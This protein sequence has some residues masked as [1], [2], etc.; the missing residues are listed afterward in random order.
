[1]ASAYMGP[2]GGSSRVSAPDA[3]RFP[4]ERSAATYPQG[5]PARPE[6]LIL[7]ADEGR[8]TG[9][10]DRM[11]RTSHGRRICDPERRTFFRPARPAADRPR[12]GR[13]PAWDRARSESV[14]WSHEYISHRSEE[15]TSE[16]QSLRHLVC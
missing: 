1:M 16:L 12:S 4:G 10:P 8:E 9:L 6:N 2:P 5:A 11:R 13:A 14:R 15:H 3:E 7:T